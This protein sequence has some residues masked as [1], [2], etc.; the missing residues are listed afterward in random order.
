MKKIFNKALK[1]KT[2][3]R[4]D[5]G[6]LIKYVSLPENS[7]KYYLTNESKKDRIGTYRNLVI[8]PKDKQHHETVKL[9]D[10]EDD[11][12]P[13]IYKLEYYDIL[14]DDASYMKKAM[15]LYALQKR[16]EYIYKKELKIHEST[17]EFKELKEL[18]EKV[19]KARSYY[20][21]KVFIGDTESDKKIKSSNDSVNKVVKKKK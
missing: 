14:R 8:N 7:D 12:D 1:T 11:R 18:L 16:I 2:I 5:L 17:G 20:S 13:I 6:E 4:K 15:L 19:K 21:F 3:S 9:Y 10:I